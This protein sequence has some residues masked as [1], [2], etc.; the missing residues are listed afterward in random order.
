MHIYVLRI[1]QTCKTH[2]LLAK[3]YIAAL[4]LKAKS[5]D[6]LLYSSRFVFNHSYSCV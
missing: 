1:A 5:D 3:N 6:I 4:E 2:H